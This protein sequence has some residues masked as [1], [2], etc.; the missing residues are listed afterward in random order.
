MKRQILLTAGS[1]LLALAACSTPYE[2]R[3]PEGPRFTSLSAELRDAAGRQV[4]SVTAAETEGGVRLTIESTSL[5]AGPHGA[6]L[7]NVG[8]CA[9]PD[10]ASA[11]P[12][13]N[14]TGRQHG[15]D[16]PNGAHAGDLPNLLVGTDGRGSLEY[17]APGLM[18]SEGPN[19][20]LDADGTAL[21]IHAAPDDH[22]TDPSGNSGGRVACGVLEPA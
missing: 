21:V 3:E 1:A 19:R 12:H 2:D 16:N 7:H 14:P 10:F 8:S 11:G 22:R 13:W 9:P 18:I 15:R 20:I 5:S 4:G 17:L 6:H